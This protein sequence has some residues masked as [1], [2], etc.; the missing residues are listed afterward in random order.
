MTEH[1]RQIG[2]LLTQGQGYYYLSRHLGKSA[3][4]EQLEKTEK[5]IRWVDLMTRWNPAFGVG[6]RFQLATLV[7]ACEEQRNLRLQLHSLASRQSD[8]L[9]D[10]VKSLLRKLQRASL[11]EEMAPQT[12][13]YVVLSAFHFVEELLY[14]LQISDR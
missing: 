8:P 13:E 4:E 6:F 5:L 11:I 3:L 2:F 14:R 12:E 1:F 10:Q 9:S 7:Q